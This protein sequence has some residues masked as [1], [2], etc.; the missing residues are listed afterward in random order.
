MI[1]IANV[2]LQLALK[3]DRGVTACLTNLFIGFKTHSFSCDQLWYRNPPKNQ[4][5]RTSDT[6][7][8]FLP[9]VFRVLFHIFTR[10]HIQF[11]FSAVVLWTPPTCVPIGG[12]PEMG[13]VSERWSVRDWLVWIQ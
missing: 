2:S 7:N 10:S 9:F 11:E 4:H 5:K 6:L 3:D 13:V 12:L 1:V 8:P